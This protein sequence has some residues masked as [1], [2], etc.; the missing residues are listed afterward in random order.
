MKRVDGSCRDMV[1]CVV[2]WVLGCSGLLCRDRE[3]CVMTE[4]PLLRQR[5]VGLV[6]RQ[7]W[8]CD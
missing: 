6:S 8:G 2:T 5:H 4:T 1:H 7:G 3:G